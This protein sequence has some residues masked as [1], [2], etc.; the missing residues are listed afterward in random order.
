MPTEFFQVDEEGEVIALEQANAEAGEIPADAETSADH[1]NPRRRRREENAPSVGIVI[2]PDP[3]RHTFE[4]VILFEETKVEI[5]AGLRALRLRDEIDRAFGIT[6]IEP[7]QRSIFNFYGDPGT[8]KTLA[9]LCI[10]NELGKR[11]F[12]VDYS[13]IISKF[14]GDTA[15]HIRSVFAAARELDAVL[16]FDEGDALLS[17][18]VDS[19]ES[20]STSINQNRAVLMQELDRF[21]GVVIVTTNLFK[22]YDPAILRRIQRH[23]KFALPN[24]SMRRKLLDLHLPKRE[25]VRANLD[26]I[27]RESRGLSGGDIRNVCINSMHAAT[28]SDDQSEWNIT[29]EIMREQVDAVKRAKR[30]HN[31]TNGR[32]ARERAPIGFSG[33]RERD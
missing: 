24:R 30:E 23:V 20:C 14:L 7:E 22:N 4:R 1:R 25:R 32:E 21:N 26:T 29:D 17:K 11:V 2:E 27:A 5:Q 19:G 16:F 31:G 10:A 3:L 13:G 33:E 12:Q 6:A 18:R 28:A 15:K 8:G 9:A